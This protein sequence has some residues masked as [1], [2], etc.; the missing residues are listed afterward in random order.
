MPNSISPLAAIILAVAT[1]G[2]TL[3]ASATVKPAFVAGPTV[4]RDGDRARIS[5]TVSVPTD[6]EVSMLDE[7]GGVIRHLAAGLLGPNAPEPFQKNSL[8]QELIWDGRDDQGRENAGFRGQG[9]GVKPLRVRVA[10]GLKPTLDRMIG[11]NPGVVI[12]PQ[13]LAVGPRGELIVIH[14]FGKIHPEDN[15]AA[16][17]VF[18]RSGKYLRTILPYPAN[19][20]EEKL[21]G[22]KRAEVAPGVKAP[23][24]YNGETRDIIPGFG[25]IVA[26]QPV[27]L[28]DGRL[29]FIG[30]HEKSKGTQL[31]YNNPGL[32]VV[33]VVNTDGSMPVDGPCRTV[34]ADRSDCG[35]AL[36]VAPDGATFYAAGVFDGKAKAAPAI[37]RFRL[38]DAKPSVFKDGFAAAT[39]VAIDKDGNIHVADREAGRVAVFNPA[40]EVIGEIKVDKPDQIAVNGR[41]GAI[42]VFTEDRRL[43]KFAS[44]KETGPIAE[45]QVVL[46]SGQKEHKDILLAVDFSSD[47]AVIW[48]GIGGGHFSSGSVGGVWRIEDKGATLGAPVSLNELGGN[49]RPSA[50]AMLSMALDRANGRLHIENRVYDLKTGQWSAGLK[51][52]TGR[53]TGI[54]QF[55]LDGNLYVQG[56]YNRTTRYSPDLKPQ[57]FGVGEKGAILHPKGGAGE[58]H[59]SGATADPAGNVYLLWNKAGQPESGD[60]LHAHSLAMHKADGTLIHAN[61]VNSQ[62]RQLCSPRLDLNGNLYL[63]IGVRPAG[64]RVP[65]GLKADFG[66]PWSRDLPTSEMEWYQLMYGCIVKFGPE[67]GALRQGIGGV[68]MEYSWSGEKKYTVDLKGAKWIHFGA[69][70]LVSWRNGAP[71]VCFCESPRFDVRSV[72]PRLLSGCGPIPRGCAGHGR[73]RDLHIRRL[74]QS[75]LRGTG[76][77]D[78]P[79]GYSPVL[80]LPDRGG[81]RHGLRGRPPEPPHRGRETGVCRGGVVHD[82]IDA[83]EYSVSSTHADV[84]LLNQHT[85]RIEELLWNEED[86][87]YYSLYNPVERGHAP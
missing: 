37:L 40:G 82:S 35:G 86:G 30:H 22:I 1:A 28:P 47:P 70:P 56:F 55:G 84:A 32:K 12:C 53:Q 72:C 81:R 15:S 21:A 4:A 63:G 2:V 7:K 43:L 80:A 27:A 78:P 34:L 6:A 46:V 50:G 83:L 31:R 87:C 19:L 16:C 62:L 29:V 5:F 8:K 26:N 3:A 61:L 9:S 10:L 54:G 59:N 14:I 67:G 68:P 73:Q 18:D 77:Q 60:V 20:P 49:N 75:R 17:T 41:T 76:Q 23:F 44:R 52:M 85:T 25:N 11:D 33:T 65:D 66:K 79:T 42:Y 39:G 69:S 71:D 51:S 48:T 57:P 13:G 64:M 36:A 74:W 58:I 38:D 45:T 24:I